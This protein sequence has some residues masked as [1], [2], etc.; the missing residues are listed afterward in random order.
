MYNTCR[1]AEEGGA[2]TIRFE[3]HVS[4]DAA[5]AAAHAKLSASR[6]AAKSVGTLLAADDDFTALVPWDFKPDGG[7]T[8][9]ALSASSFMSPPPPSPPPEKKPPTKK[10]PAAPTPATAAPE[11]KPTLFPPPPKIDTAKMTP[12]DL[13]AELDKAKAMKEAAEMKK[14]AAQAKADA[15]AAK[16]KAAKEAAAAAKAKAQKTRDTVVAKIADKKK[17]KLAEIAANAAIAGVKVKKLKASVSAASEAEACDQTLIKMAVSADD[18]ACLV[19]TGGRRRGLLADGVFNVEIAV[20]PETVDAAAAESKLQASGVTVTVVE[21][22]PSAVLATVVENYANDVTMVPHV[23]VLLRMLRTL[24]KLV[25]GEGHARIGGKVRFVGN[26]VLDEG[27]GA[28][29]GGGG[30]QVFQR[31]SEK[32]SYGGYR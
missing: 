3:I 8:P 10:P 5:A 18:A 32:P 14:A 29:Q 27:A 4:A 23:Q 20:N 7:I 6:E 21:E 15:A 31:E 17:A 12:D 19:S 24:D 9:G 11:R 22:D 30:R 13:K 25:V 28:G 16:A 2:L 26:E 1:Y